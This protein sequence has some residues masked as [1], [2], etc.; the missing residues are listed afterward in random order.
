[1]NSRWFGSSLGSLVVCS[2]LAQPACGQQAAPQ[3]DRDL[4]K[5]VDAL[6]QQVGA[7]QRDLDEIKVLLA[8]LRGPQLAANAVIERGTR[9]VKGAPA[10]RVPRGELTDYP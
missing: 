7:M 3:G 9:P 5:Q 4:Q 6:R 10:A 1:M 2:V 8:P